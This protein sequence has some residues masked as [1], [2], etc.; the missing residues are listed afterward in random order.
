MCCLSDIKCRNLKLLIMLMSPSVRFIIESLD[1]NQETCIRHFVHFVQSN[2]CCGN[3]IKPCVLCYCGL[4]DGM[5][6]TKSLS[7]I[8]KMNILK[9]KE[10]R[11]IIGYCTTVFLV[12]CDMEKIQFSLQN[13]IN[14]QNNKSVESLLRD[15][16]QT[17]IYILWVHILY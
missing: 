7:Y 12:L 4:K 15:L 8:V 16:F 3:V 13:R 9:N 5:Y 6:I 2:G 17:C 11:E 1:R 10:T 14:L